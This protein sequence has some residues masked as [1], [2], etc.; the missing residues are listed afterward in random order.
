MLKKWGQIFGDE[1]RSI[2]KLLEPCMDDYLYMMDIRNDMYSIS[3]GA[4]ERF[5]IPG[6]EFKMQRKN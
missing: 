4:V 6:A 1:Y 3:E 2:I 5:N